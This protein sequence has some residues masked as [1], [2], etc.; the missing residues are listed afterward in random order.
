[1]DKIIEYA[2]GTNFAMEAGLVSASINPVAGQSCKLFLEWAGAIMLLAYYNP[3]E[4]FFSVSPS[5]PIMCPAGSRII[6]EGKGRGAIAWRA[7]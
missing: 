1:M 3:A 4:G 5:S 6:M 7:L 2:E